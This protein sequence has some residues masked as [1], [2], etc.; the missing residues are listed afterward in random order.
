MFFPQIAA[1]TSYNKWSLHGHS[2]YLTQPLSVELLAYLKLLHTWCISCCWYIL[3]CPLIDYIF[4]NTKFP[5][6]WH[7]IIHRG[8]NICSDNTCWFLPYFYQ[9]NGKRKNLKSKKIY[10]RN[11]LKCTVFKMTVYITYFSKND[12]NSTVCKNQWLKLNG[13]RYLK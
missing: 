8:S 1:F 4:T 11:C 12:L 13:T 3:S 2:R 5:V 9:H 7:I 10:S 6:K